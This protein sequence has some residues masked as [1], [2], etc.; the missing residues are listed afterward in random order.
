VVEFYE[1]YFVKINVFSNNTV[2]YISGGYVFNTEAHPIDPAALYCCSAEKQ[3]HDVELQNL[4]NNID[5]LFLFDL[6]DDKTDI[7]EKIGKQ[8]DELAKRNNEY[9]K[10]FDTVVEFP[11]ANQETVVKINPESLPKN[12]IDVD[13]VVQKLKAA[14]DTSSNSLQETLTKT[15]EILKQFTG[16]KIENHSTTNK[17]IVDPIALQGQETNKNG[18]PLDS[19]MVQLNHMPEISQSEI[20]IKK[21]A[22]QTESAQNS[23]NS[24]KSDNSDKNDNSDNSETEEERLRE[25][26]ENSHFQFEVGLFPSRL[27]MCPAKPFSSRFSVMGEMFI[28]K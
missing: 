18:N 13:N 9:N 25:N 28:Q 15:L 17:V 19:T 3:K 4:H 5:L 14:A 24:E 8:M 26:D 11:P 21:E 7:F 22:T 10:L 1:N 6:T 16:I 12:K 27:F 2:I 20:H 23:D